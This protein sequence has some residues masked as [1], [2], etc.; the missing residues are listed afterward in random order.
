[1]KFLYD[2]E[3]SENSI[4]QIQ[5]TKKIIIFNH[6]YWKGGAFLFSN[7][8]EIVFTISDYGY[9]LVFLKQTASGNLELMRA[10]HLNLWDL[11]QKGIGN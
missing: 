3:E 11:K 2:H 1:M 10:L 5:L 6:H 8:C 7:A 4:I 9:F